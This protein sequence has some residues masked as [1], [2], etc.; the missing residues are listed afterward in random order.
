[1]KRTLFSLLTVIVLVGLTGCVVQRGRRPWMCMSGSCAQAPETCQSCDGSCGAT[2]GAVRGTS[3]ETPCDTPYDTSED[4]EPICPRKGHVCPLFHRRPA[5]EVVAP[6]PAPESPA[7]AAITYPYYTVRGPRDF[8]AK[9][10]PSIG[11]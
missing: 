1:M 4:S 7:S 10:P 6:E 5:K 2:D 3:C 8:L 9:N 11:P